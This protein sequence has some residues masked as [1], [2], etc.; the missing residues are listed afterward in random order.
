MAINSSSVYG[1]GASAEIAVASE[2]S[3]VDNIPEQQ[4]SIYD[5]LSEYAPT[6]CFVGNELPVGKPYIDAL[7]LMLINQFP[8][9]LDPEVVR[10]AC[11]LYFDR[12]CEVRPEHGVMMRIDVQNPVGFFQHC[13][14]DALKQYKATRNRRRTTNA[15]PT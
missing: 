13:Y 15:A 7:Y 14:K 10:I 6:H 8:L 2:L 12:A 4:D 9:Q 3:S 1:M 5:T 11:D